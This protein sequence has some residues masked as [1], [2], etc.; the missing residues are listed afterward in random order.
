MDGMP[1]VGRASSSAGHLYVATGFNAW[2]ITNGTA[3]GMILSD[4]ISGRDNPWAQTFDATRVKPLAGAKRF[5]SENIG[6]GAELV[7]GYL[8][9]ERRSLDELPVGEAAIVKLNGE[10]TAVFRDERGGVHSYGLRAGLESGRPDLGLLVPRLPL[11]P[12]RHRTPW[13]RDDRLETYAPLLT[14]VSWWGQVEIQATDQ[15][16]SAGR[17]ITG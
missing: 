5:I 4:L 14:I 16:G 12:G 13:S 3:A 6:T 11:H 17:T 1:F 10:R 8:Q 2:G 15:L 7:G 9:D